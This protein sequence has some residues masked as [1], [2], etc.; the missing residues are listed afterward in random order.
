MRSQP[1]PW[2]PP[3]FTSSISAAMSSLI[4]SIVTTSGQLL[5]ITHL[6]CIVSCCDLLFQTQLDGN[7]VYVWNLLQTFLNFVVVFLYFLGFRRML[8]EIVRGHGYNIE[9]KLS[10]VAISLNMAGKRMGFESEF[11]SL[12]KKH[13]M[14][15]F[16]SLSIPW[17]VR[18]RN[19][20]K[21]EW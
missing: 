8:V 5:F 14:E 7:A 15:R 3:L 11:V 19:A 17:A 1:C 13:V 4:A 2:Q 20:E 18:G 9:T 6:F 12:N 21:V 16:W 10:V